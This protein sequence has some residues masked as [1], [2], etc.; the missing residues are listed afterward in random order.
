MAAQGPSIGEGIGLQAQAPDVLT[1]QNQLAAT[2][3]NRRET[4]LAKRK[5]AQDKEDEYGLRDVN[6][7]LAQSVPKRIHP[8]LKDKSDDLIRNTTNKIMDRYT[9]LKGSDGHDTGGFIIQAKGDILDLRSGFSVINQLTDAYDKA[10]IIPE[11]KLTKE[12]KEAQTALT[13]SDDLSLFSDK[14][15]QINDP[16]KGTKWAAFSYSPETND[17]KL[18]T[19][20]GTNF[21]KLFDLGSKDIA[22]S[23]MQSQGKV[24][25]GDKPTEFLNFTPSDA[26]YNKAATS[27]AG[28]DQNAF[29]DW[30]RTEGR[31]N[32]D[33][34]DKN[35]NIDQSQ[36]GKKAALQAYTKFIKDGLISHVQDKIREATGV[37]A[38]AQQRFLLGQNENTSITSPE[39]QNTEIN[40]GN[41]SQTQD[42]LNN[43]GFNGFTFPT[44][45]AIEQ[46]TRG[47][48]WAPTST[49]TGQHEVFTSSGNS[50]YIDLDQNSK[51][52]DPKLVW[53]TFTGSSSKPNIVKD[54]ATANQLSQQ[55]KAFQMVMVPIA[56]PSGESTRDTKK[57][58]RKESEST[59]TKTQATI[60][61]MPAKD[62]YGSM[63][64]QAGS[65]EDKLKLQNSFAALQEEADANNTNSYYADKANYYKLNIFSG[66]QSTDKPVQ[67][68]TK[69]Q[70][71]S[72][73]YSNWD[74]K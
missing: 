57:I 14:L 28:S 4:L 58:G 11:N 74:I 22:R 60:Y 41:K 17:F 53:V 61:Y 30:L 2:Q 24:Y 59:N 32:T 67:H 36:N 62:A 71:S 43:A 10:S 27:I 72:N 55:G 15:D 13:K 38:L 73:V 45:E 40:F 19:L 37:S 49:P 46:H 1:Q 16:F 52:G 9:N 66:S 7:G 54:D 8:L 42:W 3:Q 39:I 35:G 18:N 63:F 65:K 21:E 51:T 64:K 33:L 69:P 25:E 44:G 56:T 20:N 31:N 70:P 23:N 6:Q 26:D 48:G 47:F 50:K 12:G 29:D 34:F 5:A 68:K